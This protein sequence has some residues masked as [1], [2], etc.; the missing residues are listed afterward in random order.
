MEINQYFEHYP[1]QYHG[2]KRII[3]TLQVANY[4]AYMVGGCIRDAL[5][6]RPIKDIDIATNA[7]LDQ[8]KK[9]F[10]R[11]IEV[12][13]AFNVCIVI[14]NEISY[15]VASLRYEGSYTDGRHP[16]L[17]RPGTLLEDAER[18]DFTINAIYYNP[19]NQQLI[20]LV[21]G[22]ED[23]QKGKLRAI[24]SPEE[25]FEEDSLRLLR[26]VRLASQYKLQMPRSTI[27]ALQDCKEGLGRISAERIY[28][29]INR[30]LTGKHPYEALKLLHEIDLIEPLLKYFGAEEKATL[31]APVED[32]RRLHYVSQVHAWTLWLREIPKPRRHDIYNKLRF[33][34]IL[35]KQI[36]DLYNLLDLLL[37]PG[38]IELAD[39]HRIKSTG[40]I[41]DLA[42]ILRMK[43]SQAVYQNAYRRLLAGFKQFNGRE[44]NPKP[45]LTGSK[46]MDLG[47]PKGP[48]LGQL[49]AKSYR[50]QLNEEILT[51]DQAV[52]FTKDFLK[53]HES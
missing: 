36:E 31:L 27:Q 44:M 4:E 41:A 17:V 6:G 21:G 39:M 14:E 22:I 10:A 32:F 35:K 19:C 11:T 43:S 38:N 52:T 33:K 26:A 51:E 8:V 30:M 5:F 12:G 28:Q 9:L 18:R 48:L 20:D 24:G 1:E 37:T 49:L 34:N 47:C 45:I 16:D 23:W 15:E 46:A 29:E 13:E 3:Q 53:L 50:K 42:A 25:R 2:A 7:N 40:L